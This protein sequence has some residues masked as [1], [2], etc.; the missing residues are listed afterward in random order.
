MTVHCHRCGATNLRPA[1]FRWGDLAYLLTLRSPVR[2]RYCR[3]RFYASIFKIPKLRRE[4]GEQR[5]REEQ[6]EQ[7]QHAADF[8]RQRL[9]DRL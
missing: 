7:M 3:A 2:C 1:H 4:A 9:G 6:A 8:H 5:A